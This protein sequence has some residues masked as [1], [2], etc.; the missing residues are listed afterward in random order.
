MWQTYKSILTKTTHKSFAE[1]GVFCLSNLK[2]NVRL[3]VWT[4]DLTQL[5]ANVDWDRRP[6]ETQTRI[7]GFF[8]F[9]VDWNARFFLCRFR[10]RFWEW[11]NE[12]FYTF[13]FSPRFKRK[14]KELYHPSLSRRFCRFSLRF[15]DT[16]YSLLAKIT[17]SVLLHSSAIK[18]E[19]ISD[20]F[21]VDS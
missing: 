6:N 17:E 12:K 16:A 11:R 15:L 14:L 20:A 13:C 8:Y 21:L 10:S 1:S 18:I 7:I 4:K 2:K 3:N 5:N 19:F 9:D